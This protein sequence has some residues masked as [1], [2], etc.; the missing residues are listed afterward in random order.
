MVTKNPLLRIASRILLGQFENRQVSLP[1]L[2]IP[3]PSA[4]PTQVTAPIPGQSPLSGI[5]PSTRTSRGNPH[6]SSIG[7]YGSIS[8]YGYPAEEYLSEL[9]SPRKRADL[10]DEMRRSDYQIKMCLKAV[11]NPIKSATWEVQ[12]ADDSEDAKLD[13]ELIEQILFHDLDMDW[14]QQLGEILTFIDFGF[15]AF[16]ITDKVVFDHPKFGTYNAIQSLGF[17]SQRTI[18]RFNLDYATGRLASV[19]QYSFGDLYKT[20]DIPAEFLILFSLDQE[21]S[22]YEGVSAL[23]SCYGCWLRKDTYMK[24]NAMGIE[25]YAIPTPMAE[26]PAGKENSDQYK[27]LIDSLQDYTTHQSAYLTF[28]AGWKIS[29][30]NNSYD[31]SKV[32]TSIDSEDKRMVKAFLANFLELGM[33]SVGSFAMSSTFQEFFVSGIEHI[34]NEIESKFNRMVIPRLIQMNRGPRDAYPKLAHSGVSDKAGKEFAEVMKYFVDAQVVVPDD[35]LEDSIRKRYK[36][37][38]KSEVGRRFVQAKGVD[39]PANGPGQTST[40]LFA[41]RIRLAEARR[42]KIKGESHGGLET[43]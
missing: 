18:E 19:T 12:P 26:I 21:G 39:I 33:N 42:Q 7:S 3:N 25:K 38:I 14:T 34:A 35:P 5:I 9:R 1:P 20:V 11:K 31:P 29:L 4:T 13:A 22:N 10:Y 6:T 24:L 8:Y 36:L 17:R 28:P 32:E 37:P 23:R 15:S 2:Q 16:E 30:N 41:E 40:S 27:N 43:G